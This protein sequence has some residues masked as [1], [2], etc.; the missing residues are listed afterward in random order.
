M[1][2]KTSF[3]EQEGMAVIA[4]MI[5]RARNNVQR[6]AGN[7]MVLWGSAIAVIA[8]LNFILLLIFMNNHVFWVWALCFPVGIIE[9]VMNRKHEKEA[10]VKTHI[11]N[12]IKGIWR[13][14]SIFT[15]LFLLIVF[16]CGFFKYLVSYFWLI[17]PIIM[18][19]TGTGM[20]GT[21]IACRFKLFMTGAVIMYTGALLC[22]AT[23]LA[24]KMEF[25]ISQFV[26]LAIC[27]FLSLVIPGMM[28]NKI[29]KK[30]V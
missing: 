8:I 2:T 12:I 16:S 9:F 20:Y 6:G 5:E 1:E 24:G 17:N 19:A 25:F 26:I 30:D 11:D 29:A 14:F 15:V 10:M 21:A 28:L 4:E 3:S 13:S 7:S 23:I 27:M 22:G 18:L